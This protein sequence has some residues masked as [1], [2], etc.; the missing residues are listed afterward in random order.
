MSKDKLKKVCEND[1]FRKS[2][3]R[4]QKKLMTIWELNKKNRK[5]RERREHCRQ[6]IKLNK[7]QDLKESLITNDKFRKRSSRHEKLL[8]NINKPNAINKRQKNHLPST[9][10]RSLS[11]Q[12]PNMSTIYFSVEIP[13]PASPET[14]LS[15]IIW[16][17]LKPHTKMKNNNLIVIRL[18]SWIE[19]KVQ[20]KNCGQY[21]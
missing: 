12:K 1:K 17:M 21:W 8:I 10:D 16:C 9:T 13:T 14:S 19:C 18:N 11:I 4:Q 6:K 5:N 20:T 7:E 2:K 3:E 15:K